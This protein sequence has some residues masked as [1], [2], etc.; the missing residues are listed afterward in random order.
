MDV[1]KVFNMSQRLC[2]VRRYSQLHLV[3][4]ES[5]MEHTGFVCFFGFL[6]SEYLNSLIED[7]E[8]IDVCKVLQKSVVHDIDEII[9]GDIPRP[10]K[11]YNKESKEVFDKISTAGINNVINELGMDPN[12]ILKNWTDAK[13]DKEGII[14]KISDLASVVYKLWD[15]TILLGNKKLLQQ[16]KEVIEYIDNTMVKVALDEEIVHDIWKNKLRIL[17]IQLRE[18]CEEITELDQPIIGTLKPFN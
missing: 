11:Y 9:T 7:G 13:K 12:I 16:A 5:V 1:I 18:I 2:S 14:V 3:K 4:D 10:T 17:M 15:E 6:L 8:K